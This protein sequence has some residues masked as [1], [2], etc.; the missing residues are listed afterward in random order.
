MYAL[1]LAQPQT[2]APFYGPFISR[3]PA[4]CEHGGA[5]AAKLPAFGVDWF[6]WGIFNPISLPSFLPTRQ[7]LRFASRIGCLRASG[8]EQR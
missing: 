6:G 2:T 4:C 3:S 1:A 7:G 5:S 8:R